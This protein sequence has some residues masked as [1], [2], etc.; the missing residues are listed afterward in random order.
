MTAP[1]LERAHRNMVATWRA[2]LA[3]SPRPSVA[4]VG[5]VVLLGSGLPIPLFNPALVTGTVDDP[6]ATLA[7]IAAHY[8]ELGSP[9]TVYFLDEL[10]P[11]LSAV[12]EAAGM[13]EHW[14]PPL[15]VLDPIRPAPPSGVDGLEVEVVDGANLDDYS[16]TL[17]GGFGMPKVLADAFLGSGPHE[18]EGL[19]LFLAR[20]ESEPVAASAVFLTDDVAGVYN[21]ATLPEARGK[22]VGAAVTWAAVEAGRTAGGTVAILQ[23]SGAGEPV[24]ARMGF[25]TPARYRQFEA[26]PSQPA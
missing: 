20:L 11:G 5:N 4:E 18:I 13:V 25:T 6:E 15:M 23:A 12:A 14:Q 3:G 21:V 1:I 24:Y 19:T 26:A 2:V 22:G 16:A 17:A 9:Y 10:T 7:D 8:G